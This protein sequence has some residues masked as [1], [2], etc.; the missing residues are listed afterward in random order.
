MCV[1]VN[2][3]RRKFKMR[4]LIIFF[5]I[6]GFV[7]G[8]EENVT[9]FATCSRIAG[10]DLCQTYFGYTNV[11]SDNVTVAI[12]TTNVFSSSHS[13]I[14]D[15]AGQPTVFMPGTY[16]YVFNVIWN[17]TEVGATP[18]A[19]LTW[20]GPSNDVDV[21]GTQDDC[22]TEGSV[23]QNVTFFVS[24]SENFG[25]DTCQ[26]S[27]GYTNLNSDDIVVLDTGINF[28]YSTDSLV[29]SDS[30]QPTTLESGTY[31]NVFNVTWNCTSSGLSAPYLP[32]LSWYGLSGESLVFASVNNCSDSGTTGLPD[33]EP[34]EVTKLI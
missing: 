17:C 8:N 2:N 9:V 14:S 23:T 26:T 33:E 18:F 25:N 34:P 4:A 16:H 31:D 28:L 27:F 6:V 22:G 20:T 11:D 15:D 19:Y 30:G 29:E 12:N 13:N 24:C 7:Y 3:N 5:L 10:T 1:Y 32:Y 21:L